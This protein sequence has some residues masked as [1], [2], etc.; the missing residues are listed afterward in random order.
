MCNSKAYTG[1]RSFSSFFFFILLRIS[2]SVLFFGIRRLLL[3]SFLSRHLDTSGSLSVQQHL[4]H[5]YTGTRGISRWNKNR[6]WGEDRGIGTL[7]T[8]MSFLLSL[9]KFAFTFT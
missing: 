8:Y 2:I 6:A 9:Y 3:V 1:S 4:P 7:T 5:F